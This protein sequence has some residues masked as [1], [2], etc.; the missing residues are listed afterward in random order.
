MKPMVLAA[1]QLVSAEVDAIVDARLRAVG[2]TVMSMGRDGASSIP[3]PPP[4]MAYQAWL[5]KFA[6][7]A[8]PLEKFQTWIRA[9]SAITIQ[10]YFRHST[11]TIARHVRKTLREMPEEAKAPATGINATIDS[12]R[13]V[14][15]EH[16][17]TNVYKRVII[18]TPNDWE[19]EQLVSSLRDV[20]T[21]P[22]ASPFLYLLSKPTRH[23]RALLNLAHG[24][25]KT[26]EQ[27]RQVEAA[28]Y[29]Q[30]IFRGRSK[31]LLTLMRFALAGLPS[32]AAS[33]A[34]N[35][36]LDAIADLISSEFGK[37]V[38]ARAVRNAP[39]SWDEDQMVFAM[40][41]ALSRPAESAHVWMLSRPTQYERFLMTAFKS[42]VK[43]FV[44]TSTHGMNA[45]L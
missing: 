37:N 20:F 21:N 3:T 30:R 36:G 42:K 23:E 41:D 38:W 25:Y 39:D 5:T 12:I 29:I 33:A 22:M 6:P 34:A 44:R 7:A 16:L 32:A 15:V 28:L 14:I 43:A 19:E 8:P 18:N 27:K 45:E 9:R 11:A 35:K 26:Q 4:Q 40:K 17:G 2:P 10:S 31:R 13:G 24:V 1:L